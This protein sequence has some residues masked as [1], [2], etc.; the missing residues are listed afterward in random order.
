LK[1]IENNYIK[2]SKDFK[3]S[4]LNKIEYSEDNTKKIRFIENIEFYK[5]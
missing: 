2:I 4:I 5:K 1:V 3:Q